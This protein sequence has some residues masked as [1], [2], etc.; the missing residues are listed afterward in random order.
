MNSK[1]VGYYIYLNVAN[2]KRPFFFTGFTLY[3]YNVV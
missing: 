2:T 1:S 3:E